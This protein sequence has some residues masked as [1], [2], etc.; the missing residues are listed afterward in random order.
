MSRSTKKGF[1]V[2]PKLY[3]RVVKMNEKPE[4]QGKIQKAEKATAA[5]KQ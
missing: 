1:S 5:M 2:Q 3:E 4:Y